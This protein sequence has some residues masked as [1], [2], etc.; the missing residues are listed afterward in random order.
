MKRA[1]DET[2][3]RRAIQ[4]QYNVEHDITPQSIVK[5]IDMSLIAVANA[6][7]VDIPLEPEDEADEM[8]QEQRT[9]FIGE[10]EE[11]MREAAKKFEFEK[12]AQ[13][14]DR[15]KALKSP[16][17]YEEAAVGGADRRG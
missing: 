17:H 1:I 9:Q 11:R 3:R 10:L 6:D 4:R 12:A 14:R 2:D 15:I 7:Y 13:Y 16:I 5:P 8:T